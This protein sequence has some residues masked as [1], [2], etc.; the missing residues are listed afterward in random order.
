VVRTLVIGCGN[1]DR[2]D[3]AAGLLVAGRLQS[4]GIDAR[5]HA[6]DGLALLESWSQAESVIIVDA[7][8]SGASEGAISVWDA[9]TAPVARDV[10][11][12]SSHAFGVAEAVELGRALGRLP[13]SLTIYGIEARQF[14]LGSPPSLEVLAAV[15]EVASR[16]AKEVHS[17][18]GHEC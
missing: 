18:G 1:A 9:R 7:V 6:G 10:F 14:E 5:E 12:A 8:I 3:D 13:P 11:R 15:E 4:L 2:G 16:I 17:A